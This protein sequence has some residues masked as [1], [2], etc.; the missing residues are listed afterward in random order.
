[1]SK[2]SKV[3][4]GTI[5]TCIILTVGVILMGKL[6]TRADDLA[7]IKANQEAVKALTGDTIRSVARLDPESGMA[8]SGGDCILVGD[9]HEYVLDLDTG[10]I[11]MF[12]AKDETVN[13]ETLNN[14]SKGIITASEAKKI[15]EKVYLAKMDTLS[16]E[17]LTFK[18]RAH[19]NGSYLYEVIHC[20]DEIPTGN[21]ASIDISESGEVLAVAFVYAKNSD[22]S[23]INRKEDMLTR[24][25]VAEFVCMAIEEYE[26]DNSKIEK[27]IVH[28]DEE[29]EAELDNIKG[30]LLWKVTIPVT[31]VTTSGEEVKEP[32]MV[33]VDAY[34]GAS[35]RVAKTLNA[36]WDYEE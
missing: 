30:Q 35:Y 8:A 14:Q 34:S 15:A 25:N 33:W 31:A 18:L 19:A 16:S 28:V 6:A 27:L 17:E 2:K 20:V 12:F 36:V 10:N 11:S 13:N 5:L 26:K 7:I 1:M 29:Y 32:Y 3:F 23:Q 21:K 4:F 9:T 24:Q 22:A